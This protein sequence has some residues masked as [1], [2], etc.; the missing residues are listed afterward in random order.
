MDMTIIG[1]TESGGRIPVRF[2]VG[3]I[4]EVL[5]LDAIH[6][7]PPVERSVGVGVVS[8]IMEGVEGESNTL[9]AVGGFHDRAATEL[10]LVVR[11]R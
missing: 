9:Y 8:R 6:S 5:D 11:A 3:D 7:V 1:G 10:R 2:C 4:V